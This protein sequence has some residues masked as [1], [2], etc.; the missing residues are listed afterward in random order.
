MAGTRHLSPADLADRE[1]VPLAS[2]Y[3]WNYRGT[4]PRYFRVGRHVRYRLADVE[5]WEREREREAV[6]RA[7]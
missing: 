1:G 6:G 2:V 7:R 3:E 5:R 4:G